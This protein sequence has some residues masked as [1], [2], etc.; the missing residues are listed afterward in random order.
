MARSVNNRPAPLS[1]RLTQAERDSLLVR[2][3]GQTLS[4]FVKQCLFDTGSAPQRSG[5]MMLANR[6][7]LAHLLATLGASQLAPNL[8]RLAK[9]AD[10]G[11]LFADEDT[12]RRIHEACD[13]VRLMHNALMRGLGKKEKAPSRK[14]LDAEAA[15]N[16]AADPEDD[17]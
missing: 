6:V 16:R 5:G 13:D 15:F 7:L 10:D 14:Q 17:E 4:A 8:D 12:I 2:A 1:V 3:G 11:D 9:E